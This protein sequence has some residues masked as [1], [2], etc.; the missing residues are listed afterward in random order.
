MKCNCN[1]EGLKS[2]VSL[3]LSLTLNSDQI[4]YTY[5]QKHQ[6]IYCDVYAGLFLLTPTCQVSGYPRQV[7]KVDAA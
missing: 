3:Y 6:Q 5:E 1:I 7:I 2:Y 4:S